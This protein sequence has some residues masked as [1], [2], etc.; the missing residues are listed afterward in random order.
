MKGRFWDQ[1]GRFQFTWIGWSEWKIISS[2]SNNKVVFRINWLSLIFHPAIKKWIKNIL[3]IRKMMLEKFCRI[4]ISKN[5]VF[6]C[7]SAIADSCLYKW[8][9]TFLCHFQLFSSFIQPLSIRTMLKKYRESFQRQINWINGF[10]FVIWLLK[11]IFCYFLLK[12][13]S[14]KKKNLTSLVEEKK[15]GIR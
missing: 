2:N 6:V 12:I 13:E 7:V 8:R 14:K 3:K 15:W 1:C 10:F 4:T 11:V 5:V 9:K